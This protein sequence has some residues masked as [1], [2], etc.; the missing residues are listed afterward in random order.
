[1]RRTIGVWMLALLL[2]ALGCAGGISAAY[3]EEAASLIRNGGAER[4]AGGSGQ[5]EGWTQDV[6]AADANGA[7]VST[8]TVGQD[9]G[10][11]G[12]AYLSV[13]STSENDARWIQTIAVEADSIYKLS[14]WIRVA[15][16]LADRTGGNLSVLG[17][18]APFPAVGDTQGEW[19]QVE[20]YGKT[21]ADQTS[22]AVAARLGS[23]RQPEQRQ[24]GLRR[25]L[26]R[27]AGGS[28]GRR[29]NHSAVA[30]S[31]RWSG[32]RR[33]SFGRRAR[34]LH[35]HDVFAGRRLRRIGLGPR[36][37]PAPHGRGDA[38]CRR[39][40]ARS[41]CRRL[42]AF[43]RRLAHS[44]SLRADH[45]RASDRRPGLLFLGESCLRSRPSRLL[46]VRHFRGLSPPATF[47]C[48]TSSACC[49][50]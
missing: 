2:G 13:S 34:Y 33:R 32:I 4:A 5:P 23:Y 28:A 7:A 49:R 17:I 9:G 47:M 10:H 11:S 48:C 37:L 35:G 27:K 46:Y 12:Q 42:P 31:I 24:G 43:C 50:S 29:R 20:W 8:L 38:A 1:M 45:A 6:Y 3:A 39:Q 41:Q 21:G 30:R 44:R 22:I 16:G 19:R 18:A 40:A 25:H 14:G 36:V 15:G 26:A